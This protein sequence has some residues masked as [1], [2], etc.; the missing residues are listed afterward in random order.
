V[1]VFKLLP[2]SGPAAGLA[3]ELTLYGRLV[4]SWH[5]SGEWF[6]RDGG[7][8]TATGSWHFAWVLGG[9]GVQ[10]V[11][12]AAGASPAEY[13]T[14]LRCYDPQSGLWHVCWMQP[15]SGEFA[16]LVGRERDGDVVQESLPESGQPLRRWSF[17]DITAD[18]FVWLGEVSADDGATWF[19]EQRMV[20]TRT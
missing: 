5:V 15:S 6:M 2:A 10:D 14:T 4:G 17:V 13:G 19:L 3:D 20:A 18:S 9:L 11:L 7:V 1:N 12:F 16:T 8:R